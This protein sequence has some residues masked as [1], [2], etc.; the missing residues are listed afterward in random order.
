MG[1][2]ALQSET[3][4]TIKWMQKMGKPSADAGVKIINDLQC[5]ISEGEHRDQS[6][7]RNKMLG[8]DDIDGSHQHR[9]AT[10]II[11]IQREDSIIFKSANQHLRSA[12]VSNWSQ[13]RA[14]RNMSQRSDNIA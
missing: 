6:V 13:I 2:A 3:S 9:V 4:R 7:V 8:Y 1:K 10:L 5:R 12:G 11:L 14:S